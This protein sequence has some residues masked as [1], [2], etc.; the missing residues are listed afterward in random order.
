MRVCVE[1]SRSSTKPQQAARHNTRAQHT[2]TE[3]HPMPYLSSATP[4]ARD[5][6]LPRHGCSKSVRKPMCASLTHRPTN[7]QSGRADRDHTKCSLHTRQSMST[8]HAV[9]LCLTGAVATP[10]CHVRVSVWCSD[11]HSG[12]AVGSGNHTHQSHQYMGWME[13]AA[14]SNTHSSVLS[15]VWYGYACCEVLSASRRRP[16]LADVSGSNGSRMPPASRHIDDPHGRSNKPCV[17]C[18]CGVV[19]LSTDVRPSVRLSAPLILPISLRRNLE[20][21]GFGSQ[22]R[23]C[24]PSRQQAWMGLAVVPINLTYL[25]QRCQEG[26]KPLCLCE[27]HTHTHTKRWI[28]TRTE[29]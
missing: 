12:V 11:R 4:L 14:A 17:W 18:R 10:D 13:T 9:P 27:L 2:H 22:N 1:K 25:V 24:K 15:M 23:A 28:N 5:E 19:L 21:V 7:S 29:E 26:I 16:S 20:G 6:Y 3:T 8:V